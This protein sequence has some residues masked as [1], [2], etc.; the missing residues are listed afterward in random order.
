MEVNKNGARFWMYH[1][2][3]NLAVRLQKIRLPTIGQCYIFS[4]CHSEIKDLNESRSSVTLVACGWWLA[5]ARLAW[6]GQADGREREGGHV[7]GGVM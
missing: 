4:L 2:R 1:K 6:A 3:N 5:A 7:A